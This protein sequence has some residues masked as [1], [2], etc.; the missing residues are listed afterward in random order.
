MLVQVFAAL[1]FGRVKHLKQLRQAGAEI[2]A[3]FG[4][5][6]FNKGAESLRGLEDG[7]VV[8]KQAKQQTHEQHF[9]RVARI[10]RAF[11]RVM[12]LAHA[13]GRF[14]IDRVLRLDSLGLVARNKAKQAHVL[15]QIGQAKFGVAAGLAIRQVVNTKAGKVADDDDLGQIPL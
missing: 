2:A 8:G 6:L 14:D 10:A 9:Q 13:F 7:R 11:E 4:S 5:A 3:V 1:A 15:V 12:Q